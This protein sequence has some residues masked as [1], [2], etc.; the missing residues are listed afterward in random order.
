L[1]APLDAEE[2]HKIPSAAASRFRRGDRWYAHICKL[3]LP[4]LNTVEE[5]DIK[6]HNRFRLL[7]TDT[8]AASS[9][10]RF[11]PRPCKKASAPKS[12]RSHDYFQVQTLHRLQRRCNGAA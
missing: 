2:E 10:I 7:A 1:L 8:T 4:A 9:T 3:R 5:V 6:A 11:L 12:G